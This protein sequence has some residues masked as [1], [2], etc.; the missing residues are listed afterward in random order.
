MT[1]TLARRSVVAAY[2]LV[3]SSIANAEFWDGTR[4]MQAL[5]SETQGTA[6][7]DGGVATGYIIAV[8][9]TLDSVYV[10]FPEG[11]RVKQIKQVVTNYMKAHPETW[12]N[13]AVYVVGKALNEVWPCP[14]KK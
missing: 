10:C 9:D 13:G 12:N 6:S 11:V 7:Y 3:A 8:A 4:L 14:V 2:L 5:E 1:A